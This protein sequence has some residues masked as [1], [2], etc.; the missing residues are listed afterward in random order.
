ML[1]SGE[2]ILVLKPAIC[3]QLPVDY[4][5]RPIPWLNISPSNQAKTKLS[6][7]WHTHTTFVWDAPAQKAALFMNK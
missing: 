6:C 1:I 4:W 2:S 7:D 3:Y 5:E